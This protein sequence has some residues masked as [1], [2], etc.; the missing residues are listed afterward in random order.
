MATADADY[1]ATTIDHGDEYKKN[2]EGE[3]VGVV[4][5]LTAVTM[6]VTA[7]HGE[8]QRRRNGRSLPV[9]VAR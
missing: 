4:R 1:R 6:A 3:R 8:V 7:R 9:G 2:R 5:K